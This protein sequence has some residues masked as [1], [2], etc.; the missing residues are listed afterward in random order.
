MA[1]GGPGG[2]TGAE[3]ARRAAQQILAERRFHAGSIPRPLHGFLHALG[4]LLHPLFRTVDHAF[5]SV[6]GAVP[7]GGFVLWTILAALALLAV[8]ALSLRSTRRVLHEGG[9]GAAPVGGPGVSATALEAA[10]VEAERAGRLQDA[11]RLRFQAGLMRLAEHDLIDAATSTPNA[12]LRRTLRSERFDSLARR[13]DEIVYGGDEAR[14]QDVEDARRE[15][16][17]LVGSRR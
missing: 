6:A 10:A 5:D 16:P 4:G 9:R 11:V 1:G 8:V 3:A 15:W 7:G 14:A 13:F 17:L 2:P 12:Q